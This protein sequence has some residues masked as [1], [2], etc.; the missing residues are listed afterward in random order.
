MAE[1]FLLAAKKYLLSDKEKS[2]LLIGVFFAT[3]GF[4]QYI[5][6]LGDGYFE[7]TK[8]LAAGNYAL[9]LS[10]PFI[11]AAIIL[12]GHRLFFRMVTP[13]KQKFPQEEIP[14]NVIH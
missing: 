12:M 7:I 4:S 6:S 2:V 9:A 13:N 10:L 11:F 5:V 3:F 8:H 14:E 1:S